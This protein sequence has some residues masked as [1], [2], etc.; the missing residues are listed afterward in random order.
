MVK[1]VSQLGELPAQLD[2]QQ[3]DRLFEVL[4][5]DRRRNVLRHLRRVDEEVTFEELATELSYCERQLDDSVLNG[6]KWDN[7]AVAL[8]HAHLPMLVDANLVDYDEHEE[9]VDAGERIEA[10]WKQ[11]DA[12][13]DEAVASEFE[14]TDDDDDD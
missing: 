5:A 7:V 3:Y 8:R 9:V 14:L 6:E 12:I 11:L 10:A 4:A 1:N 13:D 2:S